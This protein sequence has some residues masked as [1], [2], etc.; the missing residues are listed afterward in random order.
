MPQA[1]STVSAQ[2][3]K[4]VGIAGR[5]PAFLFA[6]ASSMATRPRVWFCSSLIAERPA[7]PLES[8]MLVLGELP[9]HEADVRIA[10]E[11]RRLEHALHDESLHHL[12]DLQ[13]AHAGER[14][15]RAAL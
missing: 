4:R 14:L 6:R 3:Q 8:V 5:R 10:G 15:V 1:T 11:R 2:S 12:V 7:S 13:D 9:D